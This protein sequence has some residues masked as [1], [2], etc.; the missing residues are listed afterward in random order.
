MAKDK[1]IEIIIDD[2]GNVSIE[3][4][5]YHGKGCAEDVAELMKQIGAKDK[6]VS[7]KKEY[8]QKEKSKV[9]NKRT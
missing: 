6:K 4:L 7:K 8:Y 3:A 9:Q 1:E 5:N 2:D